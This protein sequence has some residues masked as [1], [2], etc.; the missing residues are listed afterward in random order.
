MHCSMA[1]C[2]HTMP[3][4]S[5]LSQPQFLNYAWDSYVGDPGTAGNDVLEALPLA[6]M[7]CKAKP[8]ECLFPQRKAFP[9][10]CTDRMLPSRTQKMKNVLDYLTNTINQHWKCKI[11]GPFFF[12]TNIPSFLQY[13][14]HNYFHDSC[15]DILEF[16][17]CISPQILQL[18]FSQLLI[19]HWFLWMF[20]L[21]CRERRVFVGGDEGWEGQAQNYTTKAKWQLSMCIYFNS[22]QL[23]KRYFKAPLFIKPSASTRETKKKERESKVGPLLPTLLLHSI[24]NN[25]NNNNMTTDVR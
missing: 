3:Q 17:C 5:W 22:K 1:F 6:K 8:T 25:N 20:P 12:P 18:A 15:Q 14:G 21:Y 23:F 2:D 4:R 10:A 9:G 16:H 24:K 13:L 19:C 11:F 7:A